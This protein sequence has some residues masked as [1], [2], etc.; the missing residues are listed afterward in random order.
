M[1]QQAYPKAAYRRPAPYMGNQP[2]K[3]RKK[4]HPVRTFFRIVFLLL[5]IILLLGGIF[6]LIT[7]SRIIAAAPDISSITVSPTQSATYIYD[8]D[9]VR[10][11]KLTLPESNRDVISI[12]N[13]PTYLQQA[14]VAI[15]DKRF[16]QHNGIDIPGIFRAIWIGVKNRHFSEGASTITQQ[17]LK[18]TVFTSWTSETSFKQKLERKIQEQYLALQ[19]EK[20]RSKDQIL[21]D[22]MNLINLGAGCYGVQAASYCYFGKDVSSLTLSESAVIAGITQNPTRYNPIT[23]PSQNATRRTLVLDCMLDQGYISLQEYNEAL[24]DN[25]YERIQNNRTLAADSSVSVYSY[26]ED[27]LINQV[28]EDLQSELNYTYGQAYRA[29]YSGGLRIYSAQ[30]KAIQKICDE[31]FANLD[32][33]PVGSEVGID[34]ALSVRDENG[35][36]T[37]YGNDDLRRFVRQ[38]GN[39]SFNLMY[40]TSDEARASAERFRLSTVGETDTILG[41]RITITPQP[42]ASVVILDQKTGYIKAIVGGRGNKDASLTLN[43]ASYTT[44]QPGSTFKVLSAYAPALDSAGKTLASIYD[45]SPFTYADGTPVNNWDL[46]NYTGPTT[47]RKAIVKSINVCAVRCITEITPQRGFIFA[48]SLGLSTLVESMNNGTE[49]LTDITQALPLGGLTIGVSNMELCAAYASIAA[50]GHYQAPK[51]YTKVEDY[52]GNVLIDNTS[53]TARV[54]MKEA[55]AYLLT[56]AMKDVIAD[57]EGTAYGAIQM[58][59]MDVAGKTG[60]TSSYRDIWF[61]GFTPYYTCCVWGGYDNNDALPDQG[62]YHTYSKV[63]W[64]AIMSRIHEQLSPAAFTTPPGIVTMDVCSQTGLAAS[65]GCPSYTEYFEIGTAPEYYCDVHGSGA[66]INAASN[67]P[68]YQQETSANSADGIII[69]QQDEGTLSADGTWSEG[70]QNPSGEAENTWNQNTGVENTQNE[71]TGNENTAGEIT[72]NENTG[73]ENAAGENAGNEYTWNENNWNEDAEGINAGN[74]NEISGNGDW[75]QENANGAWNAEGGYENSGENTVLN[76]EELIED[77][78]DNM[79]PAA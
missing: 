39:T 3:K 56:S 1:R 20:V 47:I 49:I 13:V 52:Q 2:K 42:Q 7:V 33:F 66:H 29:V 27:A 8:Q 26:Y 46:N 6:G 40:A 75:N 59:D 19:L 48:R 30:N 53:P 54:V 77:G 79:D 36:V 25:V 10:S 38:E 31:E 9:G 12:E 35:L 76:G 34:Y 45:N 62:T 57:P 17:L 58:G 21:E 61:A 37:D 55:T 72:Q 23:N 70:T 22:Y 69:F 32:N 24:Q 51:F 50:L 5:L 4:R 18:N 16:Y 73:N 41:E 44:R 68:A 64:S 43:R 15:E 71:N 78:G 28:M 65:P 14:F 11:R 74:E 67:A 60:T 63:L